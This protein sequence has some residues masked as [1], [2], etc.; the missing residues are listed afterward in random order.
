[1]LKWL[2]K[3]LLI[4][5]S[6]SFFISATELN[7]GECNNTFFD[8]YDTYLKAEQLSINNSAFIEQNHHS[9]TLI[10]FLTSQYQPLGKHH[11][12][13]HYLNLAHY[14]HFPV[15]LFLRN[16]VW[17]IWFYYSIL[18][19]LASCDYFILSSK[20]AIC[21]SFLPI[22]WFSNL[23]NHLTIPS[24]RW[25]IK[26]FIFQCITNLLQAFCLAF[27]CCGAFILLPS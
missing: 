1:M 21:L 13:I 10:D 14:N 8:E 4:V 26:S 25:L 20:K 23:L 16:S 12:V 17:R 2:S 6:A 3:I 27:L 11:Q 15:K 7:I 19:V 9:Y 24:I 22:I 5:I 18:Q